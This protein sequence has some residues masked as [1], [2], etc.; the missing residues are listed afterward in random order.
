MRT[1]AWSPHLTKD[2]A[3]AEGVDFA[4]S[5]EEL[6]RLA[7]IVTIHMVLSDE[8]HHMIKLSDLLL[9]KKTA[10]IVNTSRGP[11]I[12]EDGL[13]RVLRENCIAGA[14]LDVFD[15]EPLPLDCP[16]RKLSNVTLTPHLGYVSDDAYK[17]RIL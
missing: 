8:T 6:L 9:M 11:L 14:G 1:L 7:D 2:K 3:D 5:K 13:V 15:M 12:D 17:V 16:L 10:L 4:E